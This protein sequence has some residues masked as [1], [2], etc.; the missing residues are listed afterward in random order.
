MWNDRRVK[1]AVQSQD[2]LAQWGDE[3]AGPPDMGHCT[4]CL[5]ASPAV[6]RDIGEHAVITGHLYHLAMI[7]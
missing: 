4:L 3:F 5:T 2:L 6:G 1:G 7:L